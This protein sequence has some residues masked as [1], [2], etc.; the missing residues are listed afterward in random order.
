M[1]KPKVYNLVHVED[2]LNIPVEKIDDFIVDLKKWHSVTKNL[3]NLMHT[4][5]DATGIK[6]V[7]RITMNWI[8]DGKHDGYVTIK[9]RQPSA[10][11]VAAAA[12]K[13]ADYLYKIEGKL[14]PAQAEAIGTLRQMINEEFVGKGK[15][16]SSQFIYDMLK[17][18]L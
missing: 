1:P 8:D 3:K 16:V 17:G 12:Q 13:T 7:E 18:V 14:T 15:Q 9:G 6:S 2:L 5:S 11:D 10:D 4:V